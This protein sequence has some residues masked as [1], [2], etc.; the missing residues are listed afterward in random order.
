MYFF[1]LFFSRMKRNYQKHGPGHVGSRYTSPHLEQ[2]FFNPN[3]FYIFAAHAH[4]PSVERR[5]RVPIDLGG[6][7]HP[8]CDATIPSRR[9]LL[10]K[11]VAQR[12]TRLPNIDPSGIAI[13]TQSSYLRRQ[14]EVVQSLFPGSNS[15]KAQT[16]K[17]KHPLD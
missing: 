11:S 16:R 10:L 15:Q 14:S 8:C 2:R 12:L 4:A 3:H 7:I 6:D 5:L 9:G 17:K 1:V 13:F